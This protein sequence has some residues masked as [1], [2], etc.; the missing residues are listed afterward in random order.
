MSAVNK[1]SLICREKPY[2]TYNVVSHDISRVEV[3]RPEEDQNESSIVDLEINPSVKKNT[4]H[5]QL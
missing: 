5:S 3:V 1:Y 2:R 4:R